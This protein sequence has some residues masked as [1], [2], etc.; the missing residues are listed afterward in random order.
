MEPINT[1]LNSV[2]TGE[3]DVD[4]ALAAAQAKFDAMAPQNQ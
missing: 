3:S 2:L 4:T 1:A